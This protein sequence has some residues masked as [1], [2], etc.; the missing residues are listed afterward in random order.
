MWREAVKTQEQSRFKEIQVQT[1][2]GKTSLGMTQLTPVIT[3]GLHKTQ[4]GGYIQAMP[5]FPAD[6]GLSRSN[7]R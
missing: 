1:V 4:V 7:D 2:W 5:S 3:A 6:Q